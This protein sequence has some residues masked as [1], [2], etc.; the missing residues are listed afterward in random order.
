MGLAVPIVLGGGNAGTPP[1]SADLFCAAPDET[2]PRLVIITL[3]GVS[4]RTLEQAFERGAFLGWPAARPLISTFPSMTNVAFTAIFTPF[5]MRPIAGYEMQ[6]YD[7]AR[8]A[9][10]GGGPVGYKHRAYGWRDYYQ[11]MPHST[12]E[13]KDAYLAPQKS[14]DTTLEEIDEFVLGSDREV[15]MAHFETTDV[16]AH[17]D[18]DERVVEVLLQLSARLEALRER[19]ERERGR[20][21]RFVLLSDHGNTLQEVNFESGI[22]DLLRES[23]FRVRKKLER[24]SDIVAE[25]YGVVSYGVLY[26]KDDQSEA[27]ARAVIAHEGVNLAAWKDGDAVVRV[28]GD[29]GEASVRWTGAVGHRRIAYSDEGGDPLRLSGA[30]ARLRAAGELGADGF[31]TEDAWFEQSALGDFPDAPRRL[32][33]SLDGT[34]VKNVAS[35]I[36]SF[37]PGYT[38]GTYPARLA[39]G[40]LGGLAGTHGGLDRVSSTGFFLTDDPTYPAGGAI[41][42]DRALAHWSALANCTALLETAPHGP[43]GAP[44]AAATGETTSPETPSTH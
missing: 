23:G 12:W 27:A 19:H 25:S 17:F 33:D 5:G 30:V 31:A 39:A 11:V 20:S 41:A 43:H 3:D 4:H 36:M 10:V 42:A 24:P 18:G 9:V 2:G 14:F 8:N 21:L 22:H 37:E 15:A 29:E 16:I 32:I 28:V 6:Y 44:L 40:L 7:H 34:F 38:W 1:P 26:T 13:K 35:V